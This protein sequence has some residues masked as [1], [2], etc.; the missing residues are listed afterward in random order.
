MMSDNL[1]NFLE[2]KLL[3]HLTGKAAYT[4][5]TNTYLGLFTVAPTDSSAG[6]EVS[7]G[8]YERA[9]LSWGAASGGSI[10]INANA[11][12]PAAGTASVNWGTIVALGIFDAVTA[13]NLLVYGSLSA[14]VTVNSG[15]SYTVT[16]G[17]ATLSLS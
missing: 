17:G 5:P 3:E 15:N 8:N 11:R 1:T 14:P 4:K 2:G 16:S 9:V 6:T 10:A 7:G 12:F 13:G